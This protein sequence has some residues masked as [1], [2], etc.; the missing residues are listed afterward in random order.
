[1]QV[2]TEKSVLYLPEQCNWYK[3]DFEPAAEFLEELFSSTS[4]FKD[5]VDTG[6]EDGI[7]FYNLLLMF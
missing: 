3:R 2:K 6:D 4:V 1:M 5:I 7:L